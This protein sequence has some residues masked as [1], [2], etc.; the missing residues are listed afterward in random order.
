MRIVVTIKYL[1][2]NFLWLEYCEMFDYDPEA[3]HALDHDTEFNL[4]K[5]EATKLGLI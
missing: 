2:S 5:E 4:T 3:A 1:I